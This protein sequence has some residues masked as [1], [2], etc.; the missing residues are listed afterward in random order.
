M[1]QRTDR[2]LGTPDIVFLALLMIVAAGL[3]LYRLNTGLWFDEIVT[4]LGSVRPPL[5]EIVTHFPS[6]N[7]HPLYSVLAHIAVQVFGEQPWVL[8]LPSALFGIAAIPMV[9]LVGVAVTNRR[10]A[11]AA[12]L[13]L[14][15]S[16]HHI[17]FSQNAR[18][19][20]A[21]LF[22]VLVSTFA[23][24]R[25][26]DTGRRAFLLLYALLT[27]I[28]AYA[29]L[30]MVLVSLSQ[31]LACSLDWLMNGRASRART[32]WKPLAGAFIGAGLLTVLCYA[33]MLMDVSSFFTTQTATRTEV[34]TPRWA[35]LAAIRGLQVGFGTLWAI[36]L[37][38]CVF[39]AGAWSYFRQKP[40]VAFLFLLPL[41][42]TVLL[43]LAMNRPIFPRFLFFATGFLLL[44]SVRGAA[45]TAGAVARFAPG[46]LAPQRAATAAIAVLTLAAVAVS[47]RSLPY[48]YRYPKQDYT[49]A[50]AFVEQSKGT[51]DPVAVIGETT[52]TPVRRYL[53]RSWLQIDDV[54]QLRELRA[55]DNPVWIVYTFPAYIAAGHPELWK[56]LQEECDEVR[57]FEGTVA[58]GTISVRRCA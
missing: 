7:D 1:T 24:I 53:G 56:T 48:G 2:T 38:A 21:L 5:S 39:T 33:P 28:G 20:T 23:L 8:R 54:R 34:A 19:Y 49:Q 18:G 46:T 40:T 9:Y 31:A 47:V 55:N 11:G 13:I 32:E 22:C 10:E 17:W 50:V 36:A 26:F 25:W 45:Y 37:G 42:V 35:I 4:L 12:A 16:Y 51:G 30:T 43:A 3:R 6:N 27:A 52:A 57:E 58:G 44:V 41:P 14:T 29:H 15:V